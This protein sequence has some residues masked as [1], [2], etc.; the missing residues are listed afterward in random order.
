[1]R[2][3]VCASVILAGAVLATPSVAKAAAWN[4]WGGCATSLDAAL[5]DDGTGQVLVTGCSIFSKGAEVFSNYANGGWE[6]Y[7]DGTASYGMNVSISWDTSEV[8]V[9][10][11]NDY[12]YGTPWGQDGD[13]W[14]QE[15]SSGCVSWVNN[16]YFDNRIFALGCTTVSS[17]GYGIYFLNGSSW[18]EQTGQGVR[19]SA[20]ADGSAI[21]LVN[22]LNR[23][24]S[25]NNPTVAAAQAGQITWS[26]NATGLDNDCAVSIAAGSTHSTAFAVGCDAQVYEWYSGANEWGLLS[27][28]P[29]PPVGASQVSADSTGRPWIIDN[30]SSHNVW[31]YY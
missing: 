5:A 10:Q 20:A 18:V 28:A 25:A 31:G 7:P 13:S 27:G 11:L 24:Y 12:Y 1:M 16:T 22:A 6:L 9:D 23:V 17:G 14:F 21:W 8:V 15:T 19:L 4:N 26:S 2:S 30:T 3:S 29:Q